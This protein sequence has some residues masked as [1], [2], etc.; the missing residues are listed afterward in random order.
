MISDRGHGN[1]IYE[2]NPLKKTVAKADAMLAA[3]A[4]AIVFPPI[5]FKSYPEAATAVAGIFVVLVCLY[6]IQKADCIFRYRKAFRKLP[7]ELLSLG[8]LYMILSVF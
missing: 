5:S 8:F 1:S 2:W 7:V 3:F 6:S 4:V